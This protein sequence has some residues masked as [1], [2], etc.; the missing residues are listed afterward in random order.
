[1]R[2][3]GTMFSYMSLFPLV[4]FLYI[5]IPLGPIIYLFVRWRSNQGV[6]VDPN[7]GVKVMVCYFKTLGY[8]L[9]LIGVSVVMIDLIKNGYTANAKTGTAITIIGG[10]IYAI[11]TLI[12]HRSFD[13]KKFILTGRI[14]N[15]FNLILVG[16]VALSSMVIWISI[17]LGKKPRGFETP[18]A[19]MVVYSLAWLYQSWKFYKPLIR[20]KE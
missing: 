16:L 12:I 8:H 9:I 11:H 18:F 20:R 3:G 1:M 2:K 7:L 4:Y 5:L 15:A 19:F 13:E 14:Y 17:I 10:L 6:A